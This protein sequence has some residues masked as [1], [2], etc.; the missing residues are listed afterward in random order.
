[1]HVHVEALCALWCGRRSARRSSALNQRCAQKEQLPPVDSAK[2]LGR[3]TPTAPRDDGGVLPRA[4]RARSLR[5]RPP[6]TS[7]FWRHT[8]IHASATAWRAWETGRVDMESTKSVGRRT[9]Q[10]R[11]PARRHAP[12][13]GAGRR[14]A[15]T[16]GERRPQRGGHAPPESPRRH[17]ARPGT[18]E[19]LVG[20]RH[21]GHRRRAPGEPHKAPLPPQPRAHPPWS[22][23]LS[24]WCL[25]MP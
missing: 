25:F 10:H 12:P 6:A 15:R 11:S 5:R 23:P 7:R 22:T 2:L 24:S 17:A 3:L 19:N 21:E 16:G 8:T 18:A 9:Q 4:R 14:L 13:D 20:D 1:M